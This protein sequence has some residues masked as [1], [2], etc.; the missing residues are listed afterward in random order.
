MIPGEWAPQCTHFARFSLTYDLL[1][2]LGIKNIKH[3]TRWYGEG[4]NGGSSL[5]EDVPA[6]TGNDTS[7]APAAFPAASFPGSLKRFHETVGT[8]KTLWAHN[9]LWTTASP[10][11]KRYPF[12]EGASDEETPPQGPELWETAGNE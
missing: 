12:A 10:Y 2:S 4:W 6:C 1:R 8:D 7:M 11:R 5:W 9:G 3:Y